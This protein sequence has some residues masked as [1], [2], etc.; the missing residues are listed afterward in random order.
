MLFELPWKD[1]LALFAMALGLISFLPYLWQILKRK[2]EPHAYTWLIWTITQGVVA[3]GVWFGGGG[4]VQAGAMVAYALCA[5]I[6]F[7]LSFWYG[8]KDIT[9]GDTILLIVALCSVFIWQGLDNPALAVVVAT[10][11]D[12][13][14]YLPTFRKSY[15]E[16][17]SENILAWIGYAIT[18][19]L[20]VFSL[21]E[22]N[23]MTGTYATAT[24]I[25]NTILVVFLLVRRRQVKAA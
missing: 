9:K 14:G 2:T 10:A 8:T 5:F 23:V 19:M 11:I 24:A 1:F 17:L 22:Y 15:Y 13:I 25:I 21:Y 18:P 4:L 12:L 7:I 16:P 6:V 20:V 3:A